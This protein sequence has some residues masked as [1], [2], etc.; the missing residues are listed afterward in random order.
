VVVSFLV[1]ILPFPVVVAAGR[2][3]VPMRFLQLLDKLR[4]LQA[5]FHASWAR[6]SPVVSILLTLAF[7]VFFYAVV[8]A[9]NRTIANRSVR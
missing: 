7:V 2:F 8:G 6:L 4:S 9:L 3:I 5:L 1:Y